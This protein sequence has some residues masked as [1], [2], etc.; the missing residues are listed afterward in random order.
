VEIRF[1]F[2]L[3]QG[4]MSR[5]ATPPRAA[6]YLDQFRAARSSSLP[7]AVAP[8]RASHRPPDQPLADIS[9]AAS[10]LDTSLASTAPHPRADPI[11]PPPSSPPPLKPQMSKRPLSPSRPPPLEK[12]E[13]APS[14]SYPPSPSPRDPRDVSPQGGGWGRVDAREELD[15]SARNVATTA[16]LGAT[17]VNLRFLNLSG[18][19]IG[20]GGRGGGSLSAK[21][22]LRRCR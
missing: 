6:S 1:Y 7:S 14:I 11:D 4:G 5:P 12:R 18:N 9:F 10:K 15:L 22:S 17:Y 16:G 20:R 8:L 21:R 2:D 13:E 19:A 3:K